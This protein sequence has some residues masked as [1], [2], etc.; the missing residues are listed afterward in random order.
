[1]AFE[2]SVTFFRVKVGILEGVAFSSSHVDSLVL[3]KD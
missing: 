1:M 2:L 3:S